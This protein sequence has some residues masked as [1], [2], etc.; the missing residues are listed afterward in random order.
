[1]TC[2]PGVPKSAARALLSQGAYLYEFDELPLED[3]ERIKEAETGFT[4]RTHLEAEL[5]EKE[6]PTPDPV[7]PVETRNPEPDPPIPNTQDPIPGVQR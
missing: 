1:M 2:A 6:E 5:K 3:F 7:E 4:E